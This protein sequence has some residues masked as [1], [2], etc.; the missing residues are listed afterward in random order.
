MMSYKKSLVIGLVS[1]SSVLSA[2]CA[3]QMPIKPPK[4]A[5]KTIARADGGVCFDREDSVKLGS[6]IMQLENGYS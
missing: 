1:I 4:P 2:S 3:Q 6:Y 5:L